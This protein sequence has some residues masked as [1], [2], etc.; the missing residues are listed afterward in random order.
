MR[1]VT[2]NLGHRA[3]GNRH[4][5]RVLKALIALEPDIVILAQRL[6]DAACGLLLAALADIG[7][8]LQLAPRTGQRKRHVLI[9]SRLEL[10]P[11]VLD[12]GSNG[13]HRPP[14][15]LHAY[16]PTGTLDVLGLRMPDRGSQPASR[17]ACWDWLLNAAETLKHRRA[18][19]I[20]DFEFGASHEH[21]GG[22]DHL[23][24]LTNEGWRHA[25]PADGAAYWT[26][27]GRTTQLDHAFLSP[28]IQPIDVR[29]ALE[30]A[31]FRLAGTRDSLSE[32]PALVVDLQ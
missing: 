20:G 31:G 6:Q 26:T 29:Y 9:A 21:G 15:V 8:K 12:D 28:A 23:R 27:D 2:W 18:V 24:R 25:A 10:V 32:Q 5:D 16:A 4:P 11:G 3:N 7:L 19:L 22:T 13:D 1:L 17:D 30:A 14:N